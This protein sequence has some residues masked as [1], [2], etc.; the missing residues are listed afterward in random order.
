[1]NKV[2][3]SMKNITNLHVDTGPGTIYLDLPLRRLTVRQPTKY[4]KLVIFDVPKTLEYLDA[5]QCKIDLQRLPIHTLKLRECKVDEVI[6]LPNLTSCSLTVYR[7]LL[8]SDLSEL[9]IAPK[10]RSLNINADCVKKYTFYHL[11]QL[12]DLQISTKYLTQESI[13]SLPKTIKKIYLYV[14]LKTPLKIGDLP[15]L[16]YLNGYDTP[17]ILTKPLKK[18]TDLS[19]ICHPATIPLSM[20]P[21]LKKLTLSIDDETCDMLDD[22]DSL[23]ITTLVFNPIKPIFLPSKL[24][25]LTLREPSCI[26]QEHLANLT[27][28]THLNI[29]HGKHDYNLLHMPLKSLY[30][31]SGRSVSREH[32]PEGC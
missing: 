13:D 1:M 4:N 15:N 29:I 22:I 8:L 19:M 2:N 21:S 24:T 32:I 23:P 25:S 11:P 6:D 14:S 5:E 7:K 17:L 27:N 10:L 20:F 31:T 12:T 16:E 30:F 3:P 28:L 9:I 18:L 26:K